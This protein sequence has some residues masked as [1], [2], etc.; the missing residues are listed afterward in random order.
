[1]IQN[2]KQ[3]RQCLLDH[4]LPTVQHQQLLGALFPA[5]RPEAR[6]AAAGKDHG[7]EV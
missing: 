2:W 4:G 5:Q 7:I 3:P 6:A 1:M